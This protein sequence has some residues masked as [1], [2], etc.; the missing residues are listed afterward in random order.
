M[1]SPRVSRRGLILGAVGATGAIG[2]AVA[3]EVVSGVDRNAVTVR[4]GAV[5]TSPGTVPLKKTV[6][7]QLAVQKEIIL[8]LVATAENTTKNWPW[9]YAYIEDIGDDRGYT[10]RKSTRLN[11]SHA[12]IS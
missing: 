6:A 10:D 3:W 2:L 12:N 7:S 8:E 5:A 1:G 4:P 11:S 9:A